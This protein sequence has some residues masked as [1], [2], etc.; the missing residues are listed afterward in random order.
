MA[1]NS[2]SGKRLA[3]GRSIMPGSPKL[4]TVTRCGSLAKAEC[5]NKNVQKTVSETALFIILH[6]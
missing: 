2:P 5:K 4:P 1:T 6:I 3:V